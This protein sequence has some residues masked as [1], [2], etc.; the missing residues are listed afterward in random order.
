MSQVMRSNLFPV[1]KEGMN[2]ILFSSGFLLLSILLDLDILTFLLS[3]STLLFVYIFRNPERQ[4]MN[5][6]KGSVLSPVDGTVLRVEEL[7]D[8]EEYALKV[9]IQ[10]SYQDISLLRAPLSAQILSIQHHKGT[11]VSQSSDLYFSLNEHVEIVFNDFE[12]N[13]LKVSHRLTKSFKSLEVDL[14]VAQNVLSTSRY[15]VM[16]SGVTT[17]YL[18]KN[19]RLNA[20]IGESL[21]AGESLMGYFS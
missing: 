1:A 10:S 2:Y 13:S 16:V 14:L 19:F 18:P 20:R 3:F 4:L 11:R 21:N 8:N 17:L 6:E 7:A 9:E 5:F 12:N 15:G